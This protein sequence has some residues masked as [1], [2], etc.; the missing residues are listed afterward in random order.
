MS[1]NGEFH[2]AAIA[3]MTLRHKKGESTSTLVSADVRL[4]PGKGLDRNVYLDGRGLPR[5][6]AMKPILNTLVMGL[7]THMR[8]SAEKGWMSEG[9]MMRYVINNLERAFVEVGPKTI[10]ATMEY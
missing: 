4:E 3:K 9:E 8:H 7:I 2:F 6:E 5:K 1:N 10:E